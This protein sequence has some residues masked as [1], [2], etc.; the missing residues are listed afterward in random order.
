MFGATEK[1]YLFF[2]RFIKDLFS[3]MLEV[4]TKISSTSL[5]FSV[6]L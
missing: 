6:F 2:K 3:L 4:A 5:D 1:F